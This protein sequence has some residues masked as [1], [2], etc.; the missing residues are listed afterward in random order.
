MNK[1]LGSEKLNYDKQLE[2]SI[3]GDYDNILNEQNNNYPN[4]DD[5]Q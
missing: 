1:E 4:Y 3:T 5:Y 2:A